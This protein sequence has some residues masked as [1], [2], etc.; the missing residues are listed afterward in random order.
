MLWML[1]LFVGAS[2]QCGPQQF[3]CDDGACFPASY[4]CD[5]EA[6]CSQGEDE[7]T[8]N[9]PDG[10]ICSA[11]DF[12]CAHGNTCVPDSWICDG[13]NDCGDSSDEQ[14]CNAIG[15]CRDDQF[16]CADG[17]GCLRPSWVCDAEDDCADGSDEQGAHCPPKVDCASEN[18]Q[19]DS[20]R[21]D[22]LHYTNDQDCTWTVTVT[23]GK[24][25]HLVFTVFDIELDDACRF[26][27]VSVYDG[28]S[29]SAPQLLKGCGDRIPAPIT[30]SSNTMTIRFVTDED[31]VRMGFSA[32][33]SAVDHQ[34]SK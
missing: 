22:V 7:A 13:D 27:S 12:T 32:S 19:Q 29:T 28:P 25:V 24:F 8:A 1:L 21:I 10:P 15:V 34:H 4:E 31:V 16:M 30:S 9:C 26:D 20:G 33:Y 11:G 23:A 2:A 14:N 17:S 3:Q 6:D 5:D 18:L